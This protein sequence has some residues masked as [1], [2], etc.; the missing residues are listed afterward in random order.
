MRLKRLRTGGD[1]DAF[2]E[3]FGYTISAEK[4]KPTNG[5][6]IAALAEKILLQF[7]SGKETE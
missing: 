7:E 6:F 3:Y 5:E 2:I 4:G 1:P